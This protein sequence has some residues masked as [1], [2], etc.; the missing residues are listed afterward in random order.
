MSSLNCKSLPVDARISDYRS[1]RSTEFPCVDTQKYGP[2]CLC[3]EYGHGIKK[4]GFCKPNLKKND[5]SRE[6]SKISKRSGKW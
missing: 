3:E 6:V 2:I 5:V 1:I 4:F